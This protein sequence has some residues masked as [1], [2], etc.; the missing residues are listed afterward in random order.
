M[1]TGLAYCG[2]CIY[3]NW[4]N[5][6]AEVKSGWTEFYIVNSGDLVYTDDYEGI[7]GNYILNGYWVLEGEK[8]KHYKI[9]LPLSED[10]FGIIKVREINND[11]K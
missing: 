1:I 3:S 10:D 2:A 11:K 7:N 4:F 5:R 6:P 9:K 8:Y